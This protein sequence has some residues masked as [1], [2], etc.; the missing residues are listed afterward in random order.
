MDPAFKYKKIRTLVPLFASCT[1][2]LINKWERQLDQ[3]IKVEEGLTAV[4]L[5]AI[6]ACPDAYPATAAPCCPRCP[7]RQS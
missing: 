7:R 4:T 3:P 1:R 6:G 5:D 2:K